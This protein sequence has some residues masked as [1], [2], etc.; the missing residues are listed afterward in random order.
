MRSAIG[1]HNMKHSRSL[2]KEP[3]SR[4]MG[5]ELLEPKFL[6]VC[7]HAYYKLRLEPHCTG[8]FYFL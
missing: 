3:P 4:L 1:L 6:R 2:L 8:I 7:I 5:F